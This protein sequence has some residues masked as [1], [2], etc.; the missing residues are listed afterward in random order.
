M[1]DETDKEIALDELARMVDP[2]AE[3]SFSITELEEV[4]DSHKRGSRWVAA[5]AYSYGETVFPLTRNGH[6]YRVV[7]AGSTGP[8]EPAWPTTIGGSVVD[9]ASFEEA[10]ADFTNVYDVRAAAEEICMRRAAATA[11]GVG[12]ETGMFEHWSA[13]ARRFARPIIA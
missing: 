5:T 9:G 8:T 12:S 2:D 11:E 13:M 3:P 10:G 1:S 7:V 4:L 6:V